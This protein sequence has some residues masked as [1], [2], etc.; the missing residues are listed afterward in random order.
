MEPTPFVH[1]ATK[2]LGGVP[3]QATEIGGKDPGVEHCQG[4]AEG[5]QA[6]AVAKF[7]ISLRE[8]QVAGK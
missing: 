5:D 7:L 4:R 1:R 6:K 2:F 3:D 8:S